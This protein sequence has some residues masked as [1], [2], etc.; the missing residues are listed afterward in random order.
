M[1][2]KPSPRK[3]A[4]ANSEGRILTGAE[5]KG[6]YSGA[7]ARFPDPG[8][9]PEYE[10][11][12][13]NEEERTRRQDALYE[14]MACGWVAR[15]VHVNDPMSR[16]ELARF[17]ADELTQDSRPIPPSL[18]R[19]LA[20]VLTRLAETGAVPH[21]AKGNAVKPRLD[22]ALE[23]ARRMIDCPRGKV[24]ERLRKEAQV[25]NMS[26][27]K[28]RALYYTEGVQNYLDAV[29]SRRANTTADK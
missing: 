21:L 1:K 6:L 19:W 13:A 26:Y 9:R 7:S 3:S 15:A 12:P 24:T 28:A 29:R 25:L 22:D 17:V 16:A 20:W 11:A 2:R 23:L 27:Q 5:I 10:S 8:S 4:G 18:R 14:W